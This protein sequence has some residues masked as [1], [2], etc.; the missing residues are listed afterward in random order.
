MPTTTRRSGHNSV[1]RLLADLI[2]VDPRDPTKAIEQ[3]KAAI[4]AYAPADYLE[5]LKDLLA[6]G[7]RLRMQQAKELR[8]AQFHAVHSNQRRP[9]EIPAAD[10]QVS[11]PPQ[12]G[13]DRPGFWCKPEGLAPAGIEIVSVRQCRPSGYGEP[14]WTAAIG[15]RL[16]VDR[17]TGKP[18][19]YPTREAAQAAILAEAYMLAELDD[20]VAGT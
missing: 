7:A 19:F 3:L 10:W 17:A 1:A 9:W 16:H 8:E 11:S 4:T 20:Q 18:H 5:T 14:S 15:G 2:I 6:D 13:S 12:D